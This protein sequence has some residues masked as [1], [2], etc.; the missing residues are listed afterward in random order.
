MPCAELQPLTMCSTAFADLVSA[1]SFEK[2]LRLVISYGSLKRAQFVNA[3]EE[4]LAPPLT[5]VLHGTQKTTS[6]S[7]Y[8]LQLVHRYVLDVSN[9]C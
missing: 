9:A 4:R 5:Q 3:L 7:M 6:F 2:T 1:D 8:A